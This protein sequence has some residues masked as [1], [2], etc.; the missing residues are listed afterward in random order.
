MLNQI[1]YDIMNIGLFV[2]DEEEEGIGVNML[3]E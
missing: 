1:S 3:H 2:G